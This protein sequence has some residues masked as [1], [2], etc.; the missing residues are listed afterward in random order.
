MKFHTVIYQLMIPTINTFYKNK[1]FYDNSSQTAQM[2][3]IK[4]DMNH[5]K[6]EVLVEEKELEINILLDKENKCISI[7]DA[8]I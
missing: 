2:H 6:K 7:T 8:G 5:L 4:L 1:K 3:V